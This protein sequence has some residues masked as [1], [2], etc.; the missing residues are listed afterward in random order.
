MPSQP[1]AHERHQHR[2]RDRHGHDQA[3][4]QVAEQQQQ[5]DD[6]EAGAFEKVVLDGVDR[7]IHEGASVV[8]GLDLDARR[9]LWAQLLDSL[10]HAG[11]HRFGVLAVLHQRDADD[12]LTRPVVG[13]GP[14]PDL[15][16]LDHLPKHADRDGNASGTCGHN[17]VG[18]IPWSFRKA[19]AADHLLLVVVLDIRAAAGRVVLGQRRVD[20]R[21]RHAVAVQARGGDPC[22]VGRH[23]A[24]VDV[25]VGD[26][27]GELELGRDGP[28]QDALQRHGR[29]A[30]P[31]QFE[32]VDL[33]EARR[34]RT[35]L[36][37]ADAGRY[38]ASGLR[39]ALEDLGAGLGDGRGV[40]EGDVDGRDPEARGRADAGQPGRARHRVLDG[41]ADETLDLQGAEARRQGEHH[42]LLGRDVR[43]RVDGQAFEV[44]DTARRAGQRQDENEPAAADEKREPGLHRTLNPSSRGSHAA[45]SL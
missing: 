4:T 39:Q 13:H 8:V 22:L 16:S 9:Q 23:L 30:G 20:L 37:I 11:D 45:G 3:R 14:E 43:H 10:L 31:L 12:R 40:V 36:R 25:H 42:H 27:G 7:A 26:A 2:Q 41:E 15:G 21:H 5:D 35:H 18:K 38:H 17:G 33:A 19:E 28:L 29:V 32:L 24:A 6:D 1:H 44:D 34:H